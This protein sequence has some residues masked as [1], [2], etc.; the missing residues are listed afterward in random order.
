MDSC[1]LCDNDCHHWRLKEALSTE[2]D[3]QLVK[4]RREC[5]RLAALFKEICWYNFETVCRNWRGPWNQSQQQS[6][7]VLHGSR[8]TEHVRNGRTYESAE[9]PVWYD[10]ALGQAPKLPPQIILN[11]LQ[12]AYDHMVSLETLKCPVFDWTPGGAKDIKLLRETIVGKP[13]SSEAVLENH[14][15][16]EDDGGGERHAYGGGYAGQL[17]TRRKRQPRERRRIKL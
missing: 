7:I 12:I 17:G 5:Q 6:R 15:H 8:L 16:G 3:E 1:P 4:A 13:H 9:F 10:G 2:A 11:E 14:V